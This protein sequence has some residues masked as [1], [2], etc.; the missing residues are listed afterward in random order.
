[1][2]KRYAYAIAKIREGSQVERLDAKNSYR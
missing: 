2:G 1:M